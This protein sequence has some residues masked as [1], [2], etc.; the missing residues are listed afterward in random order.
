M[1]SSMD[2]AANEGG[3]FIPETDNPGGWRLGEEL[4]AISQADDLLKYVNERHPYT[5][6]EDKIVEKA[7][8]RERV[9]DALALGGLALSSAFCIAI[10]VQTMSEA[11]TNAHL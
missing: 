10:S 2:Y 4:D 11:I 7:R 6:T 3:M 5:G 8:L 1:S 9:L